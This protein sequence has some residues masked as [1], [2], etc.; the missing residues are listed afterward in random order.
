MGIVNHLN[1]RKLSKAR[2]FFFNEMQKDRRDRMKHTG[3]LNTALMFHQRIIYRIAHE[4]KVKMAKKSSKFKWQGYVNINIPETHMDEAEQY[5]SDEKTVFFDFNQAIVSGYRF[6]VNYDGEDES[7]KCSLTCF[8]E[9]SP[10][11]G[12]AMSAWA[13]DWVTA[14]G[15]ILYKHF[16]LADKDWTSFTGATNKKFG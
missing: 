4:T 2:R 3:H 11:F 1:Y 13:G 5:I 16:H 12:Y 6:S 14:V 15:A 7:Y 10:N 8:D 9:D